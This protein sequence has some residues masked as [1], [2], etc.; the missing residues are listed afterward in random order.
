MNV[1][2]TLSIDYNDNNQFNR[3]GSQPAE[4]NLVKRNLKLINTSL[5]GNTNRPKMISSVII[6]SVLLSFFFFRYQD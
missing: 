5:S 6:V 4:A 3:F 1:E 2:N